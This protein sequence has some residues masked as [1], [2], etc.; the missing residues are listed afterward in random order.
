MKFS[1]LFRSIG[2]IIALMALPALPAF[3]QG[4]FTVAERSNFASTSRFA[5]VVEFISTLQ[6]R[7]P[8]LRVERLCRSTE[9]RDV[10]LLV[11]GDPPPVSPTGMRRDDRLVVYLQ[12]NIHAGE[13]EGKEAV[14]MLARDILLRASPLYLDKLVILIVPLFNADGNERISVNNRREQVGPINGVG[15]RH[16]GQL[17]DINRDA[18][19]A[20]TPEMRGF[21]RNVLLRWD[22]ELV[23]DCHTTNGSYHDEP[24]TYSW[25]LNPNG[26]PEILSY[27]RDTM[28]PTI[29][30]ILGTTY[31]TASIPYGEYVDPRLPEKGW[32]TFS[33]QPRYLTNYVGLRNRLAILDENYSYADF[34]TR[35][36]GCYHFLRSILDYCSGHVEEIRTLVRNADL[37]AVRGSATPSPADSFAVECAVRALDD[38]VTI[39]GYEVESYRDSLGRDRLRKTERQRIYTVPC[40]SDFVPTRSVRFPA[41]YCLTVSDP[42]VAE[43]LTR[44]G[45]EVERLARSVTTEAEG[46]SITELSPS[47]RLFQ[48]HYLN[49]VRGEYSTELREFVPG[50]LIVRTA[51][52]LGRLAATL[53]EPESKDG[54]LV[55]NFFD[56]SLV[57]QW[58]RG[59]GTYPVY[60]IGSPVKLVTEPLR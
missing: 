1:F 58:G 47:N 42:G 27:M 10:P 30:G 5:D 26:P 32:E 24:V 28:M 56:R 43:I 7:S 19:K 9:G 22:P 12:A 53:L 6:Q 18:V 44:H 36:E 25:V 23:V 33:C 50:T 39:R 54:L 51:Q 41:A 45:I 49:A 14:L 59:F 13:V 29:A 46:F 20:E 3:A 4:P 16:N 31:R 55:W 48:G 60:R 40:L 52:P 15:E 21:I 11:L 8:L 2:S 34:R 17:L 38:P 35:V 37:Q 57:P